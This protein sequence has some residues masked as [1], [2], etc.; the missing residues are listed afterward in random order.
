MRDI[1]DSA[2]RDGGR[3]IEET[4]EGWGRTAEL[5]G[6]KSRRGRLPHLSEKSRSVPVAIPFGMIEEAGQDAKK[7]PDPNATGLSMPSRK[8]TPLHMLQV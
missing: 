2:G 6:R 3:E 5:A 1:T 7:T 8:S 4:W